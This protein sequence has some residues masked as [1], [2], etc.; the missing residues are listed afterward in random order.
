L[1]WLESTGRDKNTNVLALSDHGHFTIQQP[2]Q[3]LRENGMAG[4]DA[5][6]VAPLLEA[7]LGLT[8]PAVIGKPQILTF[9]RTLPC[10]MYGSSRY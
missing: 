6:S 7:A 2:P 8:A 3:S 9:V 1:D 5:I 10:K 4:V